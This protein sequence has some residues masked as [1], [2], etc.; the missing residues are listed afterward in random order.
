MAY[1]AP[2]TISKAITNIQKKKYVLPAIQREFVWDNNQIEMLFD[3]LMRDYP[4]GTFLFWF[5]KDETI[6]DYTFY[7]FLQNY[8][9]KTNYLN[10]VAPKP[11]LKDKIIGILD[12]QQRL[13]SMY[14]ALQGT[15]AYKLPYYHYNSEWAFPERKF[16]LNLFNVNN[17]DN[18]CIYDFKFLTEKEALKLD[19]VKDVTTTRLAKILDEFPETLKL[20][21]FYVKLMKLTLN[22]MI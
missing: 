21:D 19:I 10:D 12:G 17:T 13:S 4:I 1:E 6:N 18:D 22:F 16:Y 11:E 20:P 7:K 5:L 9:Q 2:I 8:H 14:I 3:S 15:Y